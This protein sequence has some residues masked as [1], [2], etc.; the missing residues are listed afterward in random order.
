MSSAAVRGRG[1]WSNDGMI[2][3]IQLPC[4]PDNTDNLVLRIYIVEIENENGAHADKFKPMDINKAKSIETATLP[5]YALPQ[6]QQKAPKINYGTT[7]TAVAVQAATENWV[8]AT[9]IHRD[10]Y[11][12][13]PYTV[14]GEREVN[15]LRAKARKEFVQAQDRYIGNDENLLAKRV[16][17]VNYWIERAGRVNAAITKKKAALLVHLKSATGEQKARLSRRY[18]AEIAVEEELNGSITRYQGYK[19]SLCKT[20]QTPGCKAQSSTGW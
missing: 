2:D 15:T 10:F 19:A 8:K 20:G 7:D 1:Q 6:Q 9:D 12:K 11:D 18:K 4:S 5:I 14:K 3:Y 13:E 17:V 16:E